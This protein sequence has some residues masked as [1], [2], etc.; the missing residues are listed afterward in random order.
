MNRPFKAYRLWSTVALTCALCL[1]A[2]ALLATPSHPEFASMPT[3]LA[4]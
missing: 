2:Q 4:H 3:S 1:G